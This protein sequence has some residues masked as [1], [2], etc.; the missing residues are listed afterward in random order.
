MYKKVS[1]LSVLFIIILTGI[2]ISNP[3]YYSIEFSKDKLHFSK[4][5]NYDQITYEDCELNLEIGAPQIPVKIISFSLPENTKIADVKIVSSKKEYLSNKYNIIPV[6]QP[7]PLS[8]DTKNISFTEPNARYQQ[9]VYPKNI[10]S[11]SKNGYLSGYNIG[12]IIVYPIQYV[13]KEKKVL[14]YSKMEFEIVLED[15]Q[16]NQLSRSRQNPIITK[17]I[18]KGLKELVVN[19]Q[20][21]VKN[22]PIM[23]TCKSNLPDEDHS[24]IIITS[25]DYENAFIPLKEWKDKK[26][27]SAKIVTTSYIYSNYSGFDDA[28]K[29]RNFIIDAYQNWGTGWVLL[30]GDIYVVPHRV[31]FAMESQAGIHPSDEDEIP[32]DLYFADLDGTWDAND[33]HIYGELDDEIDL[34]PDIFVGRASV[35]SYIEAENFVDKLLIYEKTPPIDYQ[36]NMLFLAEIL[37]QNPY[38]NSGLGKDFIDDMYVPDRFDPITK[39]YEADGN[40]SVAS[41]KSA[42]NEGQSVINHNGHAFYGVMGMGNGYF[43]YY[44]ADNLINAPKFF[45]LY[46]IGCWP[47]AFDYDC[48]AEHF[49]TNPN[50]GAIAFV[51]N[52]RYGWGSPGN[53]TFGYSDRYDQQFFNFLFNMNMYNLGT[54]L[55]NSKAVHIPLAQQE[56][57]YR[58][59]M[60][61]INLLG[62]P[63]MPVWTD[64]PDTLLVDCPE[65]VPLGSDFYNIIV[66]SNYAPIRNALVCAKQLDYFY[67]VVQT[68][69]NGVANIEIS[70]QVALANVQLTVTAPNYLPF[71][72]E[73]AVST[74]S[75]CV[76]CADYQLNNNQEINPGDSVCIDVILKNYGNGDASNV[77]GILSTQA[78]EISLIDTL[79]NVGNLASGDT[80]LIDDAFSFALADSVQDGQSFL[81]HLNISDDTGIPTT[82]DIV[83]TACKPNIV[84][85]GYSVDDELYGNGNHIAEPGEICDFTFTLTNI[86]L[87]IANDV[88]AVFSA[89]NGEIVFPTSMSNLGNIA[90]NDS[91]SCI[92]S[93]EVLSSCPSPWFPL[94][95]ISITTASYPFFDNFHLTVGQTGFSDDVESGIGSWTHSG[96]NDYWHITDTESHSEIHSW[97][98]G[99]DGHYVNNMDA[100]LV[101]PSFVIGQNQEISFW[102]KYTFTNYGSDGV[103]VEYKID[104]DWIVLDFIGSGGALNILPTGND[105]LEYNYAI[106]VPPESNIQIKFR[107]VSDNEDYEEGFYLD[108]IDVGGQVYNY[109]S[110]DEKLLPKIFTIVQNYPNPFNPVTTI[111][112]TIQEKYNKKNPQIEIYNIKGQRVRVLE[113]G[114]SIATKSEQTEAVHSIIWNGKDDNN[115]PVPSGIYLYQLKCGEYKSLVKKMCLIK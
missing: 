66:T 107:F 19:K 97:Y 70:P 28:E 9:N 109:T 29:I 5:N 102:A 96:T 115:N 46:S 72:T 33:N 68:D 51:G 44:D 31:A 111:S 77:I 95:N 61:Q 35:D 64:T 52:S 65:V 58:W 87:G 3:M 32:C 98:C 26:G 101:S 1:S 69:M 30:G 85:A 53:P 71:E 99:I 108:D 57:V 80:I 37:W 56:N 67:S 104:D 114:E 34:Y 73:I 55:A 27:L 16:N 18:E 84:Y 103:Y 48:I 25:T 91:A 39:L 11:I 42:M 20:D 4:W 7:Q 92:V 79:I 90:H 59:C 88:K 45:I 47:A 14:F 105:W 13:P 12:N 110:V 93:G 23:R 41:A 24:Y 21:I 113:C 22:R 112:F 100:E 36:L 62:D 81:L 6:Q 49:I 17:I 40:L 63:E 106:D 43:A 75:S 2:S 78:E 38:T 50:G 60:Y 10:V 83:F 82:N 89:P 94:I 15:I 86:G 54:I 8:K 76:G 74:P